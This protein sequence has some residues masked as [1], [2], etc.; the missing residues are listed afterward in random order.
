MLAR[1]LM[2]LVLFCTSALPEQVSAEPNLDVIRK[3]VAST[4]A[5]AF[6]PLKTLTPEQMNAVAG[7]ILA[8]RAGYEIDDFVPPWRSWMPPERWPC[9][10]EMNSYASVARSCKPTEWSWKKCPKVLEAEAAWASCEHNNYLQVQE[11]L[12][13]FKLIS[14]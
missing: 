10:S 7:L 5:K 14:N 13:H 12:R 8:A 6:R 3:E 2:S 1:L 9:L 11:G 4:F